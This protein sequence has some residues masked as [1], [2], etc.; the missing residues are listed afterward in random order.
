MKRERAVADAERAFEAKKARIEH[1]VALV[2]Q[3]KAQLAQE[4]KALERKVEG[5]KK[6]EDGWLESER[7]LRKE[8]ARLN[9]ANEELTE[10][11]AYWKAKCEAAEKSGDQ[12][13]K[14]SKATSHEAVKMQKLAEIE[15]K[16]ETLTALQRQAAGTKVLVSSA[17]AAEPGKEAPEQEEEGQN[18]E[19][20]EGKAEEQKEPEGGEG[21]EEE[22]LRNLTAQILE[23]EEL[24]NVNVARYF[25]LDKIQLHDKDN[26]YKNLL[27]AMGA[28]YFA[29]RYSKMIPTLFAHWKEQLQAG[30]S[31]HQNEGESRE[32]QQDAPTDEHHDEEPQEEGR[33]EVEIDTEMAGQES[34]GEPQSKDSQEEPMKIM[35]RQDE[36]VV[37]QVE[38]NP[39]DEPIDANQLGRQRAKSADQEEQEY[40]NAP[41]DEEEYDDPM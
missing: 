21:N 12:Q 1:E 6:E 8:T 32:Q 29:N 14:Y 16:L 26:E 35:R 30:H 3:Q 28:L 11:V 17:P 24:K 31:G 37:M 13:R 41:F 20:T 9:Y 7:A 18:E 36:K 23:K 5:F 40:L 19:E 25:K 15:H 27:K 22:M 10:K 39:E 4:T 34:A 2:A 33:P 38:E